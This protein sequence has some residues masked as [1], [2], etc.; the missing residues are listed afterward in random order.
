MWRQ[1]NLKTLQY[2][3]LYGAGNVAQL[4]KKYF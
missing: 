4:N 2:D 1:V 3:I